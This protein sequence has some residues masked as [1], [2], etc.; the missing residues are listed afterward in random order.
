LLHLAGL[1]VGLWAIQWLS[2]TSRSLPW[3]AAAAVASALVIAIFV[4]A[5]SEP[6]VLFFDFRKAYYPAGKAVLEQP[7]SIVPLIERTVFGFV[8]LPIVAYLFAPLALM[9]FKWAA[10]LFTLLGL[11]AVFGA[12]VLLVR[13]AQLD[14][15]KPWLL[16]LLMAGNGPLHNSLKEGNTS[17][18]VFLALAAGLQ[19]L[20]AKRDLAAGVLLGVSALIKLPL[21]LFGVYFVLRQHWRAALGFALVWVLAVVLSLA[22]FGLA[23]NRRWF[24]ISVLQFSGSPIGAFNVQSIPAFLVRLRED[25]HVLTDWKALQADVTQRFVAF[26]IIGLLYLAAARACLAPSK[27]PP[28]WGSTTAHQASDVEYLL[29]LALALVGSPISWSHYYVWLLMPIAFFL[30][31]HPHFESGTAGNRLAWLGIFLITPVVEVLQLPPTLMTLYVKIG[32][33]HL[34]LGGLIWFAL[35]ARLRARA[36]GS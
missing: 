29:V 24:E 9:P 8:N 10:G 25:A 27:A 4:F 14:G 21:L 12:W 36:A 11:V 23:V 17:H 31:G 1:A 26:V 13:V 35:L 16:L 22:V 32:V 30:K 15:S 20:R 18:I 6:P 19:L 3:V 28:P 7:A 34:L 5:A 33:S 2:R